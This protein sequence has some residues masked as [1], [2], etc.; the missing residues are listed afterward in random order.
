MSQQQMSCSLGISVIINNVLIIFFYSIITDVEG[1]DSWYEPISV[2]VHLGSLTT[3]GQSSGLYRCD[4]LEKK[5][6][7]RDMQF[8]TEKDDLVNIQVYP[9]VTIKS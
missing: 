1:N 4:V 2:V 6:Q 3:S 9:L 7:S 8:F 5:C